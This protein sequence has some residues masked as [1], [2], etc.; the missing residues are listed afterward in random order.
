[1]HT[2]AY[3]GRDALVSELSTPDKAAQTLLALT[4]RDRAT[5]GTPLPLLDDVGFRVFSQNDEDGILLFLF[6]AAGAQSRTVVEL[7][8]G[9]GVECNAANLIVNHGWRALLVDGD[10]RNVR[11]A[12]WFY[13]N[14]R[15]TFLGP[16]TIVHA[17]VD[18]DSVNRVVREAGFSGEIDLLSLDM[19]GVDYWIWDALDAVSP[20]V[21]VVEFQSV[22]GGEASVTV[23]YRADF[24]RP[25]PTSDYYGAS[26]PAFIGLAHRKGFR[27]VGTSRHRFNAFFVR[28]DVLPDALPAADPAAV[29]EHPAVVE[30]VATRLPTIRGLPWVAV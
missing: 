17:W 7:C 28:H 14:C 9:D 16:P 26:L 27:F 20:R 6:A 8:A 11:R 4:Y 13:S 15:D 10:A 22:W 12:R 18:R 23:P 21:V 29:F 1:M 30:R 24:R 5:S 19:D 2:A 25:G 3:V